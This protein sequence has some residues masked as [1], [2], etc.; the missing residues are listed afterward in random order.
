LSSASVA[1][2]FATNSV[3]QPVER[4]PAVHTVSVAPLIAETIQRVTSGKLVSTPV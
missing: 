4:W 2:A 1:G 3:E